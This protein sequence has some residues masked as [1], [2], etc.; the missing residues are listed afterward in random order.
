[1]RHSAACVSGVRLLAYA[2]IARPMANELGLRNV[3]FG[4]SG[5]PARDSGRVISPVPDVS[6]RCV[7]PEGWPVS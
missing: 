4:H 3:C 5:T 7:T 6:S 1:V 2:G